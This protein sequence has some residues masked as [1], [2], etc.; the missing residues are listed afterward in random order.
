LIGDANLS[1]GVFQ[2]GNTVAVD[3]AEINFTLAI[4]GADALFHTDREG[5]FGLGAGIVN[6]LSS[7][8]NGSAAATNNPELEAGKARL[9]T[10]K[11][12]FN[13]DGDGKDMSTGNAWQV[14]PLS[15]VKNI[16][17]TLT[18]G[19]IEHKN[20]YAGNDSNSS[21]WA[22]GPFS[23]NGTFKLNS[24]ASAIVRGGGNLMLVPALPEEY[25]F[26][27]VCTWDYAGTM[28]DT[29][30]TYGILASA[31]LMS[32]RAADITTNVTAYQQGKSFAFT[33]AA[34]LFGFLNYK[35][36]TTQIG[37]HYVTLGST[38]FDTSAGFISKDLLNVKYP[39]DVTRIVRLANP[40]ALNGKITEG[41]KLGA[42][43]C[44]VEGTADP[45]RFTII[46]Q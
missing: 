2:V 32:A 15:N 22:I 26:F 20:I 30:E 34:D 38:Q 28:A 29:G 16:T 9:V 6:K 18:N 41:C 19:I 33:T 46:G 7:K 21:L 40:T 5:F 13:P 35:D 25:L 24:G 43:D 1:G 17:V 14:I 36:Y 10:G 8:P 37:N 23:G 3:G 42:L 39:A 4:N 11:P 12:V 45:A 31:P 27:P 44:Q